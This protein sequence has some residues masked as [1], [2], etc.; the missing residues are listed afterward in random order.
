[1][2]GH[3]Y[4]VYI[5][6]LYHTF[7]FS[8][9]PKWAPKYKF[10]RKEGKWKIIGHNLTLPMESTTFFPLITGSQNITFGF[11][12]PP[13]RTMVMKS[14]L[15]AIYAWEISAVNH[16]DYWR[17]VPDDF[18]HRSMLSQNWERYFFGFLDATSFQLDACECKR[19]RVICTSAMGIF[20]P[21]WIASVQC[22]CP[23]ETFS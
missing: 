16:Q 22:Q 20:K 1:M 6:G 23:F 10:P 17:R 14:C 21:K 5:L 15:Q 18:K 13:P 12:H 9:S 4:L 3:P 7:N 11:Q 19:V 2:Y 8:N